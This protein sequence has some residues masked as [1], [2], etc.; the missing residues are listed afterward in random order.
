MMNN[1]IE[2][3][4]LT[5]AVNLGKGYGIDTAETILAL[6]ISKAYERNV[7]IQIKD[8]REIF[9]AECAAYKSQLTKPVT[10][11]EKKQILEP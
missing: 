1:S 8:V 7:N 2:P 11:E 3:R 9:K 10:E 5:E 6:A 4:T